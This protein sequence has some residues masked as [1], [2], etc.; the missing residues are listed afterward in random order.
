MEKKKRKR[1]KAVSFSLLAFVLWPPRS[2]V[3]SNQW[4]AL[5]LNLTRSGLR[6]GTNFFQLFIRR[7]TRKQ[8]FAEYMAKNPCISGHP[9][10]IRNPCFR[11]L[12]SSYENK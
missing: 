10:Q 4:L 12:L 5:C 9:E 11:I 6:T 8:G 3:R 7:S 1:K 2:L